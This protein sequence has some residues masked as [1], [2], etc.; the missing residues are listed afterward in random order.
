MRGDA[1][2][3]ARLVTRPVGLAGLATVVAGGAALV[4]VHLPWYEVT[5]KVVLL[6]VPQSSS[7]ATLPGWQ[8]HPWNWV[9]PAVAL[10]AMVAGAGL[11]L[12]RPLRRTAALQ[13]GAAGALG[14]VVGAALLLA[15][16]TT[17]F[18]V[19]GSRLRELAG[20]ADRLPD[21]VE[22]AFTV[23]PATGLWLA[24]GA[25]VALALLGLVTARLR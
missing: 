19:A 2:L 14:L 25:A 12:D 21:D 11:A 10:G 5:A 13:L 7:V 9:A 17:R 23:R 4:A 18:D 20:V 15:P 22:L 3:Q 16:S 6:G 1:L 24:L 8:A